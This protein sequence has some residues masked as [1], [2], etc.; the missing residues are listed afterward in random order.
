[1]FKRYVLYR[2]GGELQVAKNRDEE[3]QEGNHHV[4]LG[5]MVRGLELNKEAAMIER[6]TEDLKLLESLESFYKKS[7]ILQVA[8]HELVPAW[9][10][11]AA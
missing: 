6:R 1:V 9:F 4:T 2:Y 7:E 11:S 8:G 3:R 5:E 10:R